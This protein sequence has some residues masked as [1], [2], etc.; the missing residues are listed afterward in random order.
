MCNNRNNKNSQQFPICIMSK[1]WSVTNIVAVCGKELHSSLC[2]K[3]LCLGSVLVVCATTS[4][5]HKL[6]SW[7]WICFVKTFWHGA[8]LLCAADWVQTLVTFVV[9]LL[10][11]VISH[12]PLPSFDISLQ[13]AEFVVCVSHVVLARHF[14]LMTMVM[15]VVLVYVSHSVRIDSIVLGRLQRSS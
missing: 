1:L 9:I 15:K 13:S 4:F 10:T 7:K 14:S 2:Y 5:Y 3:V 12:S 8:R 6:L 11:A